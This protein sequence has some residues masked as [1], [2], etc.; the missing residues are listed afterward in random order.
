MTA[1]ICAT[2]GFLFLF[3]CILLAINLTLGTRQMLV[4]F[5][6][7]F[8]LAGAAL[9]GANV[10][11]GTVLTVTDCPSMKRGA[12]VLGEPCYCVANDFK[13]GLTALLFYSF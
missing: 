7:V 11:Y 1:T 9:L 5:A 13:R 4:V 2:I 6:T 3:F 8:V 12:L 10:L